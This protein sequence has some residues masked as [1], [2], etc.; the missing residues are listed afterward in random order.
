VIA[1]SS[2][3]DP[4][5]LAMIVCPQCHAQLQAEPRAGQ[6]ETLVC[7]GVDCGLRYPVRDGIPILLIDEAG[8]ADSAGSAN[9]GNEAHRDS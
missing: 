9:E 6:V 2:G 5:L 3:I 7:Q 1:D 4:E 8:S